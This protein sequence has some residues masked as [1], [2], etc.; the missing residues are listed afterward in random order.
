MPRFA[1][2]PAIDYYDSDFKLFKA[3][4][5]KAGTAKDAKG[6]NYVTIPF[7]YD[8]KKALVKINGSFR[9]FTNETNGKIGYSVGMAVDHTNEGFLKQ[10]ESRIRSQ[11]HRQLSNVNE[12]DIVLMK[13]SK[14]RFRS[15]HLQV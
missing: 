5:Q 1:R 6:V 10:L 15:V 8:G 7:E 11:V 9:T 2:N 3:K 13:T 12:D 4:E 14:S